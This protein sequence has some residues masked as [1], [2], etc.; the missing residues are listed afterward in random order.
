MENENV[1]FICS[2]SHRHRYRCGSCKAEKCETCNGPILCNRC[3]Q[4]F[5]CLV[6]LTDHDCEGLPMPSYAER[7]DP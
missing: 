4:D 6:C 7:H 2:L 3:R 1:E 5:C